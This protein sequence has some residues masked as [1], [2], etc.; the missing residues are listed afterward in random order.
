MAEAEWPVEGMNFTVASGRVEVLRTKRASVNTTSSTLCTY[1]NIKC[2]RPTSSRPFSGNA[3]AHSSDQK[4]ILD[5][6]TNTIAKRNLSPYIFHYIAPFAHVLEHG[7][8]IEAQG[9][10]TCNLIKSEAAKS[11]SAG[12]S[13]GCSTVRFGG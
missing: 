6:A 4:T 13:Y 2:K 8:S 1:R 11:R 5:L 10:E 7:K 3:T 9:R 12:I